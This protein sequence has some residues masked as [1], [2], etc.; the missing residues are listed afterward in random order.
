MIKGHLGFSQKIDKNLL[1]SSQPN[2]TLRYLYFEV[3]VSLSFF[4]L[5][6]SLTGINTL[7]IFILKRRIGMVCYVSLFWTEVPVSFNYHF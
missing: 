1:I 5:K 2:V 6:K 4:V 3:N 7:R